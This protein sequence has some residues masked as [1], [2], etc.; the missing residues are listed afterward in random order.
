[1][2]TSTA[3]VSDVTVIRGTKTKGLACCDSAAGRPPAAGD[4][5]IEGEHRESEML[6]RGRAGLADM[7]YILFEFRKAERSSQGWYR[8]AVDDRDP[9][10]VLISPTPPRFPATC[11]RPRY[12]PP[13]GGCGTGSHASTSPEALHEGDPLGMESGPVV[14]GI[15]LP[16]LLPLLLG[17]L[18]GWSPPSVLAML[19]RLETELVLSELT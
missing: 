3:C 16:C 11:S 13:A 12:T 15:V 19:P 17:T 4:F 9:G 14:G 7:W 1:M 5:G 10:P 6:S 2:L 18:S 8:V